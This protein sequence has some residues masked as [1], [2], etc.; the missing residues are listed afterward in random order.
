MTAGYKVCLIFNYTETECIRNISVLY[1]HVDYFDKF[2]YFVIV[3]ESNSAV[4]QLFILYAYVIVHFIV[5]DRLSYPYHGTE[6]LY[7]NAPMN[8]YCQLHR[9]S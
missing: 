3:H 4:C 9:S 1:F 8:L 2:V 7:Y 5:M 6:G